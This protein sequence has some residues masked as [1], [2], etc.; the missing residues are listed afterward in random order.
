MLCSSRPFLR[1]AVLPGLW[2]PEARGWR[3]VKL[4]CSV[5]LTSLDVSGVPVSSQGQPA[6]SWCWVLG[7]ALGR[8]QPLWGGG[9]GYEGRGGCVQCAFFPACAPPPQLL[10]RLSLCHHPCPVPRGV[11]TVGSGSWPPPAPASRALDAENIPGSE[12]TV[13]VRLLD[14]PYYQ[15]SAGH[16]PWPS[17]PVD[18]H[19]RV[20]SL[21]KHGGISL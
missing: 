8:K 12:Q 14:C 3:V 17:C 10:S 18:F 4:A 7:R 9:P 5:K 2:R 11:L 20:S 16:F 19:V 6:T 21:G 13:S 15:V 1:A